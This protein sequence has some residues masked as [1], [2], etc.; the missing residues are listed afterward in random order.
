MEGHKKVS[1]LEAGPDGLYVRAISPVISNGQFAGAIEFNVSIESIF[2]KVTGHSSNLGIALLL[3]VD[4]LSERQN[5][6][7]CQLQVYCGYDE[8]V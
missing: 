5:R 1:G 7:S 2:R 4:M 6:E 3:P 8:I